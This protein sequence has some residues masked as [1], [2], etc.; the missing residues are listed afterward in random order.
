MLSAQDF[1]LIWLL[2]LTKSFLISSFPPKSVCESIVEPKNDSHINGQDLTT[3]LPRFW[4]DIMDE[5]GD[6]ET[7][8]LPPMDLIKINNKWDS[9]NFNSPS[10][11][12]PTISASGHH[13]PGKQ[14]PQQATAQNELRNYYLSHPSISPEDNK[15]KTP[16]DKVVHS[17]RK[18]EYRKNAV[19]HQETGDLHEASHTTQKFSAYHDVSPSR[20]PH[21]DSKGL[22]VKSMNKVEKITNSPYSEDGGL[23][24]NNMQSNK[25][26]KTNDNGINSMKGIL[27]KAISVKSNLITIIP[28]YNLHKTSLEQ[29][30]LD[31]C[32][33][34]NQFDCA[35]ADHRAKSCGLLRDDRRTQFDLQYR[36]HNLG[37]TQ[38]VIEKHDVKQGMLNKKSYPGKICQQ[39]VLLESLAGKIDKGKQISN[40]KS[41][42]TKIPPEFLYLDTPFVKPRGRNRYRAMVVDLGNIGSEMVELMEDRESS[43]IHKFLTSMT[44]VSVSDQITEV[45]GEEVTK[46]QCGLLRTGLQRIHRTMVLVY[47]GS[48]AFIYRYGEALFTYDRE[49]SVQKEVLKAWNFLNEHFKEWN[50]QKIPTIQPLFTPYKLHELPRGA[51]WEDCEKVLRYYVSS[52]CSNTRATREDHAWYL[53]RQWH[54]SVSKENTEGSTTYILMEDDYRTKIL[55]CYEYAPKNLQ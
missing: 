3:E 29:S 5:L 10:K 44:P 55:Q 19:F 16:V 15:I 26:L 37:M 52:G 12:I 7:L 40:N 13:V 28:D 27:S 8:D 33:T 47:L 23:S 18:R 34:S 14:S 50:H 35:V 4:E 41:Q 11:V 38:Q 32:C 31:N 42:N 21:R 51:E 39:D 6:I 17:K 49:S 36:R 25:Y 20:N 53:V 22:T 54:I 48:I 1:G 43:V 46:K 30:I 9:S 2:I 24:Q 45:R